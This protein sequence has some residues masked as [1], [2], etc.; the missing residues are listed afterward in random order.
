M[1]GR[2]VVKDAPPL[3]ESRGY[4]ASSLVVPREVVCRQE[5]VHRLADC[6][7]VR[8]ATQ[9]NPLAELHELTD[10]GHEF[11]RFDRGRV[12]ERSGMINSLWLPIR[13]NGLGRDRTIR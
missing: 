4:L 1:L 12:D 3:Q 11:V 6:R 13:C 10:L 7:H 9:R 5:R 8:R 2:H